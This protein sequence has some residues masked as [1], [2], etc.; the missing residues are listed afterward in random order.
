M[1]LAGVADRN[2][3]ANAIRNMDLADGPA[4]YFPGNR[5]RFDEYGRR[6]EAELLV[7]QWQNGE[8]VTVFPDS[9]A[10]AE[11]IWPSAR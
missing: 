9:A 7:V 6:I 8:P 5:I 1:K 10:V 3:V 4:N 11:P 2:E